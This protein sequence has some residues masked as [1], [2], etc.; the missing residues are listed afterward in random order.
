[1]SLLVLMLQSIISSLITILV[2]FLALIFFPFLTNKI[3]PSPE[4]TQE[5]PLYPLTSSFFGLPLDVN[6]SGIDSLD[7][8]LKV[9]GKVFTTVKRNNG[10]SLTVQTPQNRIFTLLVKPSTE[11]IN[12]D[13]PNIESLL[14]PG[15]E[16]SLIEVFN[17]KTRTLDMKQ[18]KFL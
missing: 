3:F 8:T 1:M 9:H 10:I 15:K 17:L 4:V 12:G 16:I 18:L 11:I 14:V 7:L 2:L 6:D 13:Y 5:L